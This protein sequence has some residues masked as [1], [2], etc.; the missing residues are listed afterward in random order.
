MGPRSPANNGGWSAGLTVRDAVVAAASVVANFLLPT[1][2]H[3][4][5]I[6]TKDRSRRFP[7]YDTPCLFFIFLPERVC[8]YVY[9]M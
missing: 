7:L 5:R 3:I 8:C 9:P 2:R 4:P 6:E 1:I